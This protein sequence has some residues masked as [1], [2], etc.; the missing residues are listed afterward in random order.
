VSLEQLFQK[1]WYS[2]HHP[3][4]R[5]LSP[6]AWLYGMIAVLRRKAYKNGLLST[7]Q[8]SIP[9]VIVGNITVG[10]TGKTPLVIWIYHYLKSI[11]YRPGIISRGY[12]GKA[13]LFPQQVR[14]DSDPEMVGDEPVVLARRCGCPIAIDPDRKSAAEALQHYY[15]CDILISDDGLQHYALERD[16]EIVV[17]DGIRRFGNGYCLPAGP[18]REPVSR[19][20]TADL[21]VTNGNAARG[22]FPMRLVLNE[23]RQLRD[24][25]KRIKLELL[26]GREVHAVSGIGFPERFFS[27]LSNAGLVVRKHPFP[28]HHAYTKEDVTFGDGIP[29]IMTEKDA[30]KCQRFA[31]PLHWYL[32]LDIEMPDVFRH[33]LLNLI[34]E[35]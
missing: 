17:I 19:L 8:L 27:M 14:A 22:E 9:V 25:K 31:T 13:T 33:R 4:A 1:I 5:L 20:Q 3:L 2:E 35:S 29:V 26:R 7:H 16:V 23:L 10:G 32:P 6:L 24:E 30:V 15:D 28:D 18:L 21:V 12:G 11:G 34:R